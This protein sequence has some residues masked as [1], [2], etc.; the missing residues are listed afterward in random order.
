M[1]GFLQDR[2]ELPQDRYRATDKARR[3]F[4]KESTLA[5]VVFAKVA[6]RGEQLLLI[7]GVARG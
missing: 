2:D 6:K 1:E 4:R 3:L 5:W 7:G